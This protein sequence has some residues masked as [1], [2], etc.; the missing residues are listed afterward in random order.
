LNGGYNDCSND[1]GGGVN[2]IV[3]SNGDD[4]ENGDD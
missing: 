4:G 3:D 1:D 2:G